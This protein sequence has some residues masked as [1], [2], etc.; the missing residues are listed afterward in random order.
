MSQQN[1]RESW[2]H[3]RRHAAAPTASSNPA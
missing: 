2:S 3:W 1:L